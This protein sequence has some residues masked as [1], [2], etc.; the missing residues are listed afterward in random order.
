MIV[1]LEVNNKIENEFFSFLTL[2]ND[3]VKVLE[4]IEEISKN[5]DDYQLY[6]ERKD[7]EEFSM[8][9]VKRLLSGNKV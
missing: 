6:L 7:E 3:K 5:E 9:E 4:K 1:T 2:L 8:D